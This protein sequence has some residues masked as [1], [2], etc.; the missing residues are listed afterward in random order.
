M[1]RRTCLV[2]L[3]ALALTGCNFG[4]QG[5]QGEGPGHR[6]QQLGMSPAE[7]LDAGRQAYQQVLSELRGRILPRSDPE[8]SRV[9]HI[10]SRLVA[11]A[12]IELLQKEIN[13]RVQGYRF[14]WEVNVAHDDR[15]NAFCLPGGK[16]IVFTGILEVA[17]NDDQLATVLSHEI[18]HALAHHASE[19]IARDESGRVSFLWQKAYDRQQ[20]SEADHIGVFLM[21]F[22]SY[23]PEE[24]VRF[25]ERM[26]QLENKKGKLPEILSDH[27]S[28][29]R[30]IRDLRG[31]ARQAIEGKKAYD[32]GRV[33]HTPNR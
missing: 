8:V 28:D 32:E 11:A 16:M 22:A 14:E 25:W 15:V 18:S 31:W 9:R 1:L 27:P 33:V 19:R 21:A 23:N 26:Q 2:A 30:R 10:V 13:L 5:P 17:Q 6:S 4:P 3:L 12:G 7:E 20:E 24:A 29:A